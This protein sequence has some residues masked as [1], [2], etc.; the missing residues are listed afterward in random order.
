[1]PASTWNMKAGQTNPSISG[2]LLQG[3]GTAPDCSTATGI[4]IH[5]SRGRANNPTSIFSA[6]A[7]FS[8]AANG[9]WVYEQTENDTKDLN[10]LQDGNYLMELQVKWP[11]GT[12]SWF[13]DDTNANLYIVPRL[14]DS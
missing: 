12:D 11:D 10:S 3:D 6:A 9:L 4:Y 8:D 7:A 2:Q 1:M 14:G 5:V 13:P